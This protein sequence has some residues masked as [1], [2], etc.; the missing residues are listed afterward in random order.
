MLHFTNESGQQDHPCSRTVLPV[1]G[2]QTPLHCVSFWLSGGILHFDESKTR[3]HYVSHSNLQLQSFQ[4]C[5]V[6]LDPVCVLK[7]HALILRKNKIKHRWQ[8]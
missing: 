4:W 8:P 5:R 7:V 1:S 2:H 6:E 3:D